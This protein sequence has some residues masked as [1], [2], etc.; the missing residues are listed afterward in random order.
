MTTIEILRSM[1]QTDLSNEPFAGMNQ[2]T[3]GLQKNIQEADQNIQGLTLAILEAELDEDLDTE[4][5]L[6]DQLM[7]NLGIK[8]SSEE[9]LASIQ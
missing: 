9:A 8:Q 1:L 7:Y 5:I 3:E 2:I 4:T 6:K